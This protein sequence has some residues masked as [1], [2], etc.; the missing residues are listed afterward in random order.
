[1]DISLGLTANA[2]GT[3]NAITATY[4]PFPAALFDRQ[5]LFFRAT[6]ANTSTAPTFNPNGTGAKTIV[7]K[8]GQAL[9]AGDIFGNRHMCI[10]VYDLAN[11]RWE[12]V[13]PGN[14]FGTG[15]GTFCQG[16]D[17]RLSDSRY[18]KFLVNDFT[19]FINTGSTSEIK[20][21]SGLLIPANTLNSND[22][23][24]IFWQ[25]TKSGVVGN[26]TVR[27]YVNT[28]D[29]IGGVQ[30]AGSQSTNLNIYSASLKSVTNKNSL[31]T[32]EVWAPTGSQT[33]DITVSSS[34]GISSVGI[35]WAVDNYFVATIQNGSAA[36]TCNLNQIRA[37]LYKP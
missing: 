10:V 30:V 21:T 14:P 31:T 7:K 9:V 8:G 23:I 12:L 18:A 15:A 2:A 20:A 28:T 25:A 3:V 19:T 37:L 33:T 34:T 29:T 5:V 22:Q 24:E 1:M 16:N 13:N 17:S 4:S 11:T 27:V 35:N 32:Q 26:M 6:G 36:D